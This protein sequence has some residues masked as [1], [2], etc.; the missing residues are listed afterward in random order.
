MSWL[1]FWL[2]AVIMTG[3]RGCL[4]CSPEAMGLLEEVKGPYLDGKLR[5]DT[6]RRSTLKNLLT[7]SIEGLSSQPMKKGIYMGVID[8]TTLQLL[9]DH[10]K[11]S[12]NRI[13]EN[14][15]DGGQ[16]FNEIT[17]SLQDL[18]AT[19]QKLQKKFQNERKLNVEA[20][21]DLVLDCALRWHRYNHGARTYAFYRIVGDKEQQMTNTMD[22]F[23]M[24]K[25]A[26]ANDT[27]RYRCKML[28]SSGETYSQIDFQVTV[29]PSGKTTWFPRPHPTLEGPIM[30]GVSSRAP[31]PEP[32][33]TVWIVIGSTGGLLFIIVGAF[34]W[35]YRRQNE[36]E[37]EEEESGNDKGDE[38]ES[39][40]SEQAE[41]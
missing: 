9:A 37:E 19:F 35:Y 39:E 7:T 28:S 5:G 29:V 8:E 24:K 13:M 16:L 20:D 41:K 10:F 40:S 26:N 23:L 2:P 4:K 31:P 1:V 15:F 14:Q 34:L 11:R 25:E 36:K 32:D 3:S 30:M 38:D 22:S 27:G 6:E 12:M 18:L 33:W 17:W 21:E